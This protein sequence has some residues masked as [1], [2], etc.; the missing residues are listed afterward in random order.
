MIRCMLI[1]LVVAILSASAEA[2]QPP[3]DRKDFLIDALTAQRDRAQADAA[4]C[5]SDANVMI[6]KLQAEIAD[7]K[8]KLPK[9]EP[10]AEAPKQK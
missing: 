9:D 1:A 2:Q 10:K 5:Y 4:S 3:K 6:A 8:A 7:L